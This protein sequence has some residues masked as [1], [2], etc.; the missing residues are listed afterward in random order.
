MPAVEKKTQEPSGS[1]GAALAPPSYEGRTAGMADLDLIDWKLDRLD[2]I[3]DKQL[4]LDEHVLVRLRGDSN[5]ALVCTDRRVLILKAGFVTGNWFRTSVWQAP[6]SHITGA[7]VSTGLIGGYIQVSTG[8]EQD[9]IKNCNQAKLRKNCM[10]LKRR[11]FERF[12]RAAA[13]ISTRSEQKIDRCKCARSPL[14]ASESR[15]LR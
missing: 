9:Q 12:Q 3:L 2:R 14:G 7:S 11:Q 5:E 6:Y 8:G 13:F 15:I 4:A 10:S 1:S